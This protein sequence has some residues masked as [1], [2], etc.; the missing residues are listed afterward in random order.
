MEGQSWRF[1]RPKNAYELLGIELIN[2]TDNQTYENQK[3]K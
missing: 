3:L 1:A 2:E